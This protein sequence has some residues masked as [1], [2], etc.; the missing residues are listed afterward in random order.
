[1]GII[2]KFLGSMPTIEELEMKLKE[3]AFGNIKTE[4]GEDA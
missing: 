1:M 4:S 2:Y 3:I